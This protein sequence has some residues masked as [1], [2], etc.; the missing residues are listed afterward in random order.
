MDSNVK[1]CG[2]FCSSRSEIGLDEEIYSRPFIITTTT[3]YLD[4]SH[5]P[6]LHNK[7]IF[8]M[9]VLHM[10]YELVPSLCRDDALM[11]VGQ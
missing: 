3:L 7:R 1:I 8:V 11:Q 5:V 4:K 10:R 9:P 6:Y 2:V